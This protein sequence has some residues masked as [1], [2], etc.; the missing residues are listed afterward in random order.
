MATLLPG[1]GHYK[2]PCHAASTR[3]TSEHLHPRLMDYIHEL[4]CQYLPRPMLV[5]SL[6]MHQRSTHIAEFSRNSHEWAQE[7]LSV[8]S[9]IL[10]KS[11]WVFCA[12]LQIRNTDS[13]YRFPI[14][15]GQAM[16]RAVLSP[17]S[18]G[19][20]LMPHAGLYRHRPFLHPNHLLSRDA[21]MIPI[22]H[23][24]KLA[25]QWSSVKQ[26]FVSHGLP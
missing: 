18:S 13:G 14:K 26:V 8:P 9:S 5:L 15:H 21:N 16:L 11:M 12:L 19:T 1:L 6:S 24:R 4:T 7:M 3:Y 20:T 10:Q 23:L 25:G 22:L 2:E 17:S